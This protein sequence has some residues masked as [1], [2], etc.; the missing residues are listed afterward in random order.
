MA[1]KDIEKSKETREIGEDEDDL[2]VK[3]ELPGLDKDNIQ[4]NLTDH[5]PNH[6]RREKARRGDQE[7]KLLPFGMFLW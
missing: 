2:L 3:D 1:R 6:Q 5:T 4:V 7:G